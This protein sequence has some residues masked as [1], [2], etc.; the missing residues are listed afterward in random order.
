[1][2]GFNPFFLFFSSRLFRIPRRFCVARIRDFFAPFGRP[3]LRRRLRLPPPL[4]AECGAKANKTPPY[5]TPNATRRRSSR[6]LQLR[7]PV[8][9]RR[10]GFFSFWGASA[11]RYA[12]RQKTKAELKKPRC[13]IGNS[14][15]VDN[16]NPAP[17]AGRCYHICSRVAAIECSA[18]FLAVLY[19]AD[20]RQG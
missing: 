11:W 2:L 15:A 20:T 14:P 5:L 9:A 16:K 19:S 3:F 8:L 1:M 17:D 4:P 7:L 18:Y 12:P 13:C 6:P 10:G